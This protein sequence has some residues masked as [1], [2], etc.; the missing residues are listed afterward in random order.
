M[1]I[2]IEMLEG[3]LDNYIEKTDNNIP[4]VEWKSILFQVC[5]GLAV[6]QKNF[7]FVLVDLH[8]QILCLKSLN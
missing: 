5:F 4:D 6:A 3:T 1:K 8:S 7:D 2:C